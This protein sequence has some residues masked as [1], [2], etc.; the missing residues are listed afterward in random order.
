M[1]VT[2]EILGN[3]LISIGKRMRAG[4]CEVSQEQADEIFANIQKAMFI[5]ISKEE[6][7]SLLGISRSTFDARVAS[8][9]LPCGIHRRG[10][11]EKIWNKNDLV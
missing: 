3:A 5:P 11:K 2:N 10:F 8:G 6:A 1:G 7:C 4:K 9:Q